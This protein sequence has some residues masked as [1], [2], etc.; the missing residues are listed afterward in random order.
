MVDCRNGRR[1]RWRHHADPGRGQTWRG[2]PHNRPLDRRRAARGGEG[3]RHP[4]R[5]RGERRAPARVLPRKRAA[6][7]PG[8]STT[9]AGGIM[10]NDGKGWRWSCTLCGTE[11]TLDG[12]GEDL[13]TDLMN[14]VTN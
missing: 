5:H 14:E 9:S 4:P 11:L 12:V 7:R 8:G 10:V 1:H 13:D 2:A 3:G 6:A